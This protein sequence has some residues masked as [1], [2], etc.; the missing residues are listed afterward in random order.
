MADTKASGK[1]VGANDDVASQD[2]WSL[3]CYLHDTKQTNALKQLNGVMADE[4][5][6][7]ERCRLVAD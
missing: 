6:L 5:G 4:R 7:D 2:Y 3:A 1:E